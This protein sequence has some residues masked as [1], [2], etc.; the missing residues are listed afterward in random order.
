LIRP[1]ATLLFRYSA[2]T[3]N[4]HRIHYDLPYVTTEEGYPGLVVHGPLQATLLAQ[5]AQDLRGR[6]PAEFRFRSLSPLFHTDDMV[7][8][9]TDDGDAMSLWTARDSGP[10]AMEARARW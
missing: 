3:F 1:D 5:L 7:L 2:L 9:A 6:V 8:N 10:V 4:G